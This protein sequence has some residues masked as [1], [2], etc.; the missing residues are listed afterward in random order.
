[1]KSKKV[2]FD[3][4]CEIESQLIESGIDENNI[5]MT[6]INT[7]RSYECYSYRRGDLKER[8]TLYVRIKK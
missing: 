5:T 8:M 7:Y 2:Y 3:L 4:A 6:G 1:M